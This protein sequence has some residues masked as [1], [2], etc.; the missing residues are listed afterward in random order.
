VVRLVLRLLV[1]ALFAALPAGV[2]AVS[3]AT[4]A[5]GVD[6]CRMIEL[7]RCQVA[8]VCSPGFDTNRCEIFYRDECLVGIQNVEGGSPSTTTAEGCVDAINAAARCVG[9][10][11]SGTCLTLIPEVPC[12]E[13]DGA[14][15]ATPCNVILDCPEAL[16]AC[17]FVASPVPPDAGLA[18]TS[19]TADAD[20][21][22]D[23]AP[24]E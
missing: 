8:P 12:N 2:A 15:P 10:S 22:T 13:L 18:E 23:D 5:V 14:P 16:T 4:G 7:A 9:D 17:A 21:D 3:C 19:S 20:A 11:D 1:A 24:D 6:A